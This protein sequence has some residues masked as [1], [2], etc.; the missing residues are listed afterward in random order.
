M[1]WR[2]RAQKNRKQKHSWTGEIQFELDKSFTAVSIKDGGEKG[3]GICEEDGAAFTAGNKNGECKTLLI[4]VTISRVTGHSQNVLRGSRNPAGSSAAAQS[5]RPIS[6]TSLLGL[7][8]RAHL[9][10]Q[11]LHASV[12]ALPCDR[13]ASTNVPRLLLD[14]LQAQ[15][16]RT[17][18]A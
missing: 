11:P 16:L 2:Q 4:K 10:R 6:S 1:S 17:F 5:E 8:H 9:V 12:Q 7:D 3:R 13:V 18:D 14:R 15:Q